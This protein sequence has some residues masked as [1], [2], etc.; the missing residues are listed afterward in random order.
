M[1]GDE[2][3]QQKATLLLEYQEAEEELAHLSEK[4]SAW[5]ARLKEIVLCI[6]HT[7]PKA[8]SCG[9]PEV[10]ARL[11]VQNADR[12]KRIASELNYRQSMNLDAVLEFIEGM[13]VA[14]IKLEELLQRKQVLGLR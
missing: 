4:A 8:S 2:K 10:E 12:L 1:T 6:E 3:R 14:Q 9:V 5:A 7:K 13:Q 11:K